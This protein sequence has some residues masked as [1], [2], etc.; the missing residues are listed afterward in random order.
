MDPLLELIDKI[1]QVGFAVLVVHA[2]PAA[3][4]DNQ[5]EAAQKRHAYLVKSWQAPAAHAGA[6][7]IYGQPLEANSLAAVLDRARSG[8]FQGQTELEQA[9]AGLKTTR[10]QYSPDHRWILYDAH[11]TR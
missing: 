7:H 1:N 6:L 11:P 5:A 9:L 2:Q 3:P 4:T 8:T 10:R